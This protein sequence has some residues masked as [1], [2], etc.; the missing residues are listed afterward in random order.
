M[1]LPIPGYEDGKF[2]GEFEDDDEEEGD[3]E[4]ANNAGKENDEKP[5]KKLESLHPNWPWVFAMRG[6]DRFKWWQQECCKRIQD[7][8]PPPPQLYWRLRCI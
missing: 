1:C 3:G 5:F 8:F 2:C 4:T 6:V 7:H